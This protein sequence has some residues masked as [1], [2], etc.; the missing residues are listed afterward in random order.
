MTKEEERIDTYRKT[1]GIIIAVVMT[2]VSFLIVKPFLVAILSAAALAYIFYPFYSNLQKYVRSRSTAAFVICALVVLIVVIPLT[3]V[4]LA[5]SYEV[6]GG[7]SFLKNYL[8]TKQYTGVKLPP[9]LTQWSDYLPQVTDLTQ[10]LA[11][12]FFDMLQNILKGIPN[13]ALSIF[14]TVFS[15][16]YFLKHG[17]DIYKFFSEMIP[18]S[19]GRYKQILSR[20]DDLSRGM[21]MGQ[22]VVGLVQGSLAWLGFF[23]L[24]V[25]NPVLWGS[26]TAVIS[27]IPLLGAVIIWLPIVL[28][29]FIVGT[30]TGVYWKA[31]V[32][33]L[34]GTFVVS[35][36]DNI[37]KPKIVGERANIHPL[38]ILFGI[39]GGIQLFGIPGILIGPLVLTIFDLVVE[40]Y[41]ESL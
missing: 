15:C 19:E 17:K 23:C 18:L 28:Y 36:I 27:I 7:Y 21:L 35:T 40:I 34:Y 39:L 5:L 4:T 13:V 8:E 16:Y 33:L 38:I 20:F 41:K 30:I 24:G 25:P 37:L 6:K 1:I 12:Q 11:N 3:F 26:L 2:I 22:I 29:L 32:L 10:E 14:V 31:I 9:L